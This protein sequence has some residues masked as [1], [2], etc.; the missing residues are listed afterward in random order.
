[1]GLV[2]AH[3]AAA[4]PAH[5]NNR[6]IWLNLRD[7]F[8]HPYTTSDSERV[9]R[10]VRGSAVETNVA[11][12]AAGGGDPLRAAIHAQPRVVPRAREGGLRAQGDTAPK[13]HQGRPSVRSETVRV[14]AMTHAMLPA[15]ANG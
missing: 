8:P 15:S 12:E 1:M 11:G 5:A 7:R 6:H 14:H 10:Y 3:G 9:I 2:L 13:R 4:V